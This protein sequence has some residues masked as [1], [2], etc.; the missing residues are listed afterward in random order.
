[1]TIVQT[2]VVTATPDESELTVAEVVE[3][4]GV[5]ITTLRMYQQRG[6]LDPPERRGRNAVYRRSHVDRLAAIRHLQERGYS[7]AAIRDVAKRDQ[8]AIERV[9]SEQVPSLAEEPIAMTL[10][11]LIQRLPAADFSLDTI[12][13]TQQLGVLTVDG[14]TVIVTQPAFLDAGAALTAMGVPTTAILDSYERLQDEVRTIANDFVRLFD[15]HVM[16]NLDHA[17]I[18]TVTHQL[19]ALTRAAVDVVGAELRRALRTVASAR[20]SALAGP[21]DA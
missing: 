16:S 14:P 18:S 11:E 10:L 15:E 21:P 17:D 2:V 7:L 1:M 13:R 20:I 5:P 6:L 8:G 12:R 3:A 9:L 19:D 4:S